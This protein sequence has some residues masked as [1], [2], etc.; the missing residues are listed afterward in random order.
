MFIIPLPGNK[1]DFEVAYETDDVFDL[2]MDDHTQPHYLIIQENTI[3]FIGLGKVP[4]KVA[5]HIKSRKSTMNGDTSIP[6]MHGNVGFMGTFSSLEDAVSKLFPRKGCGISNMKYVA[7][8]GQ[9]LRAN[10]DHYVVIEPILCLMRR[11]PSQELNRFFQRLGWGGRTRFDC[12]GSWDKDMKLYIG[13]KLATSLEV[14][15]ANYCYIALK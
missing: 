15:F 13:D 8:T 14:W 11:N 1:Q 5:L 10:R 7:Y 2:I 9:S 12:L 6:Q 4:G 3:S